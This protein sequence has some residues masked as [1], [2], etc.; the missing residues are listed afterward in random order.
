VNKILLIFT[1]CFLCGCNG[2][3]PSAVAASDRAVMSDRFTE[4]STRTLA[5]LDG[6]SQLEL[7]ADAIFKPQQARC[8]E[9]LSYVQQIQKTAEE[10]SMSSKLR[11]LNSQIDVCRTWGSLNVDKFGKCLDER[12]RLRAELPGAN[13]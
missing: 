11:R 6:L 7:S 8:A 2:H 5:C 13:K 9:H 4:E 1:A 12:N 3:T 10:E